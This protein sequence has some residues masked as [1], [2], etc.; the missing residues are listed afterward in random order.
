MTKVEIPPPKRV[1]IGLKTVDCIFIGY[2]HNST[3]YRF[4]IHESNIP[5]IHEN[6]IMESRNT[7]FF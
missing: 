3:A 5:D 1:K 6:T 2:E 7:S 4:L